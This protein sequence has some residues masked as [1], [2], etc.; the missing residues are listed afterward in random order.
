MIIRYATKR[1]ASGNRKYL[2]VNHKT[3]KYTRENK[4]WFCREDVIEI[5]QGDLYKLIDMLDAEEY[6]RTEEKF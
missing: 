1:N 2:A 6:E 4:H 3:K 5:T